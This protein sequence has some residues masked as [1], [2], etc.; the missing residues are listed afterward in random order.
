MRILSALSATLALAAGM[1]AAVPMKA[2]P[3]AHAMA[4]MTTPKISDLESVARF[5]RINEREI[6]G[7]LPPVIALIAKLLPANLQGSLQKAVTELFN[8]GDYVLNGPEDF[9]EKLLKL[10]IP[11]SLRRGL[12]TLLGTEELAEGRD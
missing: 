6:T 4:M 3:E 12:N 1:A 9:I 8:A 2:A 10:D 11:G 5:V 7:P